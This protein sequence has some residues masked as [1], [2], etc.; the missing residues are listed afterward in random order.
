MYR[1]V[2]WHHAVRSATAM[3][4]RV[5]R[6]A[7]AT[8][9]LTTERV[10]RSTD[11]ELMGAVR[12]LAESALARRLQER[13][14][15]KRAVDI[16]ATDVPG[17]T[18]IARRP[19]LTEAIENRMAPELGLGPG[20]VLLDFPAKPAM[21]AVDL[22][23]LRRNGQVT[24]LDREGR[25]GLLG[26]QGVADELHDHA[27]RLRLFV[28]RPVGVEVSR[29]RSLAERSEEEVERLVEEDGPLLR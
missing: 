10:S 22:P 26:I 8:G 2:Y 20:E 25:S 5:V 21:L 1:N 18:W 9:A 14:L 15:Y 16:A 17:G 12:S 7:I 4:R 24:V 28:A 27:R 13:H 19:D 11:E 3:F 23:L 29:I 6:E